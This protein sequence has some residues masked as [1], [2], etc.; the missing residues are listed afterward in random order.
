VIGDGY[1]SGAGAGGLGPDGWSALLED[2]IEGAD[3]DLAADVGAGY[4]AEGAS[5]QTFGEIAGT[6]EVTGADVVVV[7]GSRDDGPGIADQVAAA[8]GDL[9]AVVGE[10]APDAQLIVVGPIWPESPAPAGARNNRDVLRDA[11]EAAGA[12]F[13]DP[14]EDGWLVDEPDLLGAD[15]VYP[16]DE[17]HAYL[18]DRLESAIREVL[19]G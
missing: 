15:G 5:G 14:L 6:A 13:V 1:A 3:V 9:F 10:R 16:T 19:A 17:G 4:V 11:A 2:R 8:A 12:A 18:A 7:L